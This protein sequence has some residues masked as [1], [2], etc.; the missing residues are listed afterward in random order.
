MFY[1]IVNPSSTYVDTLYWVH[2]LF[3]PKEKKEDEV[4][5]NAD[6]DKEEEWEDNEEEIE[7]AITFK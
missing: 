6:E 7:K 3:Y 5:E 4:K 1:C 2:R